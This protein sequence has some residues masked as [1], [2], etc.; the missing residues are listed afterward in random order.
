MTGWIT[1]AALALAAAGI[2]AASAQTPLVIGGSVSETGVLADLAAGYRKGLLLW[3]EQV[4]ASGG[5]GG[6]T[7]KLRLLDD[8]SEA[9][10]VGKLYD[11]L[12]Q[13]EHADALIGP[14][15]SA[16]SMMAAA[17]AE[18]ARRVIVDGAAPSRSLHKRAPRYVFQAA[19][20]YS[21]YGSAV[22]EVVKAAGYRKV[23]VAARD[24]LAAREMGDAAV[25]AAQALGLE[26][27]AVEVFAAGAADFS[28]QIAKARGEQADA[29]IAFG[30][31]RDAAQMVRS[32][33][34]L[35]YA[36]RLFFALG[37]ADRK[38][39]DAV[40]QDAEYTLTALEYDV[41]LKTP[42]N[43]AFVKAFT[44]KWGGAP[45]PSAAQGYSAATVLGAAL[46][47]AGTNP[48]KQREFLA[49]TEVPTVLGTYR[50]DPATGEQISMRP[51]LVQIIRGRPRFVW[52][53]VETKAR[54]LPYPQWSERRPLKP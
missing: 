50:V 30:E 32:F 40:G 33:R 13:L 43:A 47:H 12:M 31:V 34:E 18:R 1:R 8:A 26:A 9:I 7:V 25:Q 36:P 10:S 41:R 49:A 37:A 46:R 21:M 2:A 51:A 3:E 15:G 53:T 45:G 4:N 17:Q 14:Y 24:D 28:P 44:A 42:G 54:A 22:L 38:F 5:V 29:W 11:R 6:R 16:A 48:Q 20:P 39:T 27:G 52:P 35:N 23:L 19:I